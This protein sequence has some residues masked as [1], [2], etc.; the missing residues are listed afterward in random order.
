M[1]L[2][3]SVYW[4]CQNSAYTQR[5]NTVR[6]SRRFGYFL[7]DPRLSNINQYL[8][9][10]Y[11]INKNRRLGLR[12][13]RHPRECGV[14][15]VRLLPCSLPDTY[16]RVA[17]ELFRFRFIDTPLLSNVNRKAV[18][19]ELGCIGAILLINNHDVARPS[20]RQGAN[21]PPGDSPGGR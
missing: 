21:G 2:R 19:Y 15:R 20:Y 1:Y 9:S 18:C 12:K 10:Y 7:N 14:S 3:L 11:W 16:M 17:N 13:R 6:G 5:L 8:H 4:R